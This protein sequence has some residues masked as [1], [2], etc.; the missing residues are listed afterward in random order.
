M[1]FYQYSQKRGA[2]I[3]H[4]K[5]LQHMNKTLA[6]ASVD[7]QI[8]NALQ[9]INNDT[10]SVVVVGRFS[11]GKSTFINALLG[12]RILPT[13]KKPTTAV[14]SK[15]TYAEEPR[16]LIHY[17]NGQ[18]EVVNEDAFFAIKALKFCDSTSSKEDVAE[19]VKEQ[20]AINSIDFVEVG[21][22]LEFCKNTVE[23]VDTPGT[24]DLNQARIDITYKYLNQ[25][26]AVILLLA[27]DQALS[28]GEVE[29]L[30]EHILK[31]NIKDIFYII[32][33]KDTLN[34]PDEEKRVVQFVSH[35]LGNIL[36]VESSEVHP[37]L[38][39]SYQALLCRRQANGESLSSK[40]QMQLPDNFEFTGFADFER[41]LQGYLSEEKGRRRLALYGRKTIRIIDELIEDITSRL[42]LLAHSTDE[43]KAVVSKL[44]EKKQRIVSQTDAVLGRLQVNLQCQQ[45]ALRDICRIGLQR[46]STQARE[47]VQAYDGDVTDGAINQIVQAQLGKGQHQ[48]VQELHSFIS[49]VVDL[50]YAMA[51]DDLQAVWAD[52]DYAYSHLMPQDLGK[53]FNLKHML[54]IDSLDAIGQ[55]SMTRADDR[56]G[57]I[58]LGAT[59]GGIVVAIATGSFIPVALGLGLAALLES[60]SDGRDKQAKALI[61]DEING[62]VDSIQES[63]QKSVLT[64]YEHI[65]MDIIE[66]LR[67]GVARRMQHM[68]EQLAD[69]LR[70]KA[71]Q[72]ELAT[73]QRKEYGAFIEE[74]QN[75]KADLAQLML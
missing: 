69:S 54:N 40:Q 16:C 33:R 15:I 63:L 46:I 31:Q 14:I 2:M 48:L 6:N 34:G 23:L 27:A 53:E 10:F 62:Q 50:E 71:K 37:Y 24:D 61:C 73:L 59:V 68:E 21:Y 55:A 57:A 58:N 9:Y 60:S 42:A 32:N 5:E 39:S 20:D 49:Q 74:L 1:N 30:E 7:V 26:D 75:R 45:G 64:A 65:G 8:T 70:L 38:V 44:E 11:R 19:T 13:S 18:Q 43:I 28:I 67:L 35:N 41:S 36:K 3:Q 51:T 25:A 22:P 29:F 4:L 17:K 47:L 12:R 72:E 66:S 56:D 52:F